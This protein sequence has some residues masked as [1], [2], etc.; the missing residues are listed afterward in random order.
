MEL[1]KNPYILL[2]FILTRLPRQFNGERIVL[3]RNG[4]ATTRYSLAKS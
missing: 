1:S 4:P 2:E 3:S